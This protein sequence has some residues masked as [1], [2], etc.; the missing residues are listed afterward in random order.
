VSVAHEQLTASTLS[1]ALVTPD[2]DW[3][4]MCIAIP[5]RAGMAVMPAYS[6]ARAAISFGRAAGIVDATSLSLPRLPRAT[7]TCCRFCNPVERR[8]ELYVGPGI[9]LMIALVETT[10]YFFKNK[11]NLVDNC[12]A[13]Y[14]S[15]TNSGRVW[16]TRK[17][18]QC[19][20][21]RHAPVANSLQ[22]FYSIPFQLE[23]V[24][25]Y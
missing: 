19:T 21:G 16:S 22:T 9:H 20:Y 6:V 4:R 8:R 3:C 23:S 7:G 17:G 13:R 2:R 14:I 11:N 24:L 15:T 1:E 18:P 5:E 25:R 10:I 12:H